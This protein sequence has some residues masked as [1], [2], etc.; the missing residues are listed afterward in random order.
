VEGVTVTWGDLQQDIYLKYEEY[1]ND[2]D[3]DIF[4]YTVAFEVT[5]DTAVWRSLY[6]ERFRIDHEQKQIVLV[7]E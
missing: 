5:G 7:L 2:H 3:I 4:Q 6:M 1:L